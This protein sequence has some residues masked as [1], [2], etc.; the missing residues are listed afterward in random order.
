MGVKLRSTAGCKTFIV[1]T[2]IAACLASTGEISN[3]CRP[4]Y[5]SSLA[6]SIYRCGKSWVLMA[7]AH[8]Y[9][10]IYAGYTLKVP[11]LHSSLQPADDW[12]CKP[13]STLSQC[14]EWCR[15]MDAVVATYFNDVCCCVNILQKLKLQDMN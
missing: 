9:I 3:L 10:C 5:Y 8:I 2:I 13:Q 14:Q 11:L 12:S 4:L 7:S 1:I 15:A 6:R